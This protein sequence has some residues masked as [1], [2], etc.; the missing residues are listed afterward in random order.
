[1]SEIVV[2][3][4]ENV[5]VSVVAGLRR[6]GIKAYTCSD[7]QNFGLSDEDQVNFA[8]EKGFVIL[9]HDPDFLRLVKNE[10]LE[11]SGIIFVSQRKM[12]TGEIIRKLEQLLSFLSA[13]DMEKRV[14]FL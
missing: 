13:E 14:E 3:A 6:R 1:M 12:K 7:F 11:H 8:K 2:Y 5:D 10:K 4:D 9:T